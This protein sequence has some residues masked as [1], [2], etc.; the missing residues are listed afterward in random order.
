MSLASFVFYI[1]PAQRR[2]WWGT[3]GP[4]GTD[5]RRRTS[6]DPCWTWNDDSVAT[7]QSSSFAILRITNVQQYLVDSIV[8]ISD[9]EMYRLSWCLNCKSR[10]P[11]YRPYS[12][13]RSVIMQ[14]T[15]DE[16]VEWRCH[17]SRCVHDERA[18]TDKATVCSVS[19]VY[20]D[21]SR[22]PTARRR[23]LGPD[24]VASEITYSGIQVTTAV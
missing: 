19:A 24:D 13:P 7:S 20:L 8:T 16:A 21:W 14:L 6:P 1:I 23:G 12:V 9:T 4:R 22:Q 18:Y 15:R 3:P 17:P 2:A 5:G 10:W 11:D